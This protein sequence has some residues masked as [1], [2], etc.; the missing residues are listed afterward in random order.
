MKILSPAKINLFLHVK[1][2]RPDGYHELFT[3]MCPVALFDTV[4]LI[5]GAEKTVVSCTDP[6]VPED[7]TN[8]A[9]R[10]AELFFK[11]LK[12]NECVEISIDKNIPVAAGLGGGSSNAAAVFLGL[13]RYYNN[14]FSRDELTDMGFLI[15]ADVPFFIFQKPATVTGVG[16]K[17]EICKGLPGFH[18]LLVYPGFSVSTAE[19]YKNLNLGLT[20]CDKK[21]KYP[22]LDFQDFDLQHYL[23]N[24]LE[25]VTAS[26]YPEIDVVKKELLRHG[27]K[28]ALMS[29][30]GSSVFGLFSDPEK[31]EKAKFSLAENDK[32]KVFLT[33]MIV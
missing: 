26:E 13:N 24:D 30:S 18:I 23:C 33:E 10:A 20:N 28:G 19:V 9:Y 21:L 25:T 1:K 31:A 4:S 17:L 14:P 11:S 8:L 12:I 6:D 29:G 2:K 3:L 32:W 7:K 27:A 5:F 16:E 22:Q 15:G